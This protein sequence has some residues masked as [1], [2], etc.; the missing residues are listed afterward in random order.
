M[1]DFVLQA[2]LDYLYEYKP[3]RMAFSASRI[4]EFA[5]W[6]QTFKAELV[7]LLGLAGRTLP[8]HPTAEKLQA[9]DKGKYIEEKYALNVGQPVPAPMYILVPKTP[10]PYKAII[11]LHGHGPGVSVILGNY[12]NETVAQERLAIDDNF[13]QVLAEAGYLVCAI[14]QRGF[15]ERVTDQIDEGANNSCRHLAFEYMLEGRTLLGERIWDAMV[16][17]SYI[18]NR[19]DVVPDVLG[20]TGHSGGGTTA[21]WMS[22]IDERITVNVTSCYFCALK[23]S[24]LGMAH[25]EC[26][27]VPGI[28]EFAEMGDLGAMLAPHPFRIIAG[29]VDPIFPLAGVKQEFEVTKRAYE[30][31]DV[32]ENL[33]LTVH[34]GSHA[35][36]H[37][38][39]LEWFARWL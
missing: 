32:P 33:S 11:A 1:T 22:A 12:P 18:K 38:M 36:N 21:L 6:K 26:N 16:A 25:C 8:A 13:A 10:P 9:V 4:T 2:H 39:S 14:E 17:I 24:I 28:L 15:G 30:L 34:P 19:H 29:E 31:L 5:E 20:C 7:K 23:Q 27:Y 37:A 3:R 35:Y